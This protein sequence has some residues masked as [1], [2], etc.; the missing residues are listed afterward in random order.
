[1]SDFFSDHPMEGVWKSLKGGMSPPP[2]LPTL[3]STSEGTS[4][5]QAPTKSPEWQDTIIVQ[6]PTTTGTGSHNAPLRGDEQT[7]AP[8]T[9][10]PPPH[11]DPDPPTPPP[12]A[13]EDNPPPPPP[14]P[15]GGKI[16]A[17]G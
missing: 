2:E 16:S 15:G 11:H 10:H 4:R 12:R 1:M 8:P 7:R 17:S 9:P 3:E 5:H 14:P 6:T 13:G